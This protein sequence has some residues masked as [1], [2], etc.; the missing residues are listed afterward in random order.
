MAIVDP[1]SW[2]DVDEVRITGGSI[3]KTD[4]GLRESAD[5]S[6]REFERNRERWIRV[7]IHAKQAGTAGREALFT[8]LAIAPGKEIDGARVQTPLECYSVLKPADD[9]LMQRGWYAPSGANGAELVKRLLAVTPAPV[10]IEGE[11]PALQQA[12]IAEDGETRLS[13]ADKVLD[14]IGWRLRITGMGEIVICEKATEPVYT[15]GAGA[16]IVEPSIKIEQDWFDCPNVFRAVSDDMMAVARDD[17]EDSALSTEARGREIW[18]EET[19]CDMHDGETVAD[20]AMRRLREEQQTREKISY[21]RRFEPEVTVTDLVR[22]HYPRAQLEGVYYVSS[23]SIELGG[24]A[25][26]SEEVR[27]WT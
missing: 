22:L 17:A 21:K 14:A 24:G 25:G 5:I 16:D 26:V 7:W 18:K 8:G 15:F 1:E 19:S 10:I 9:V 23:Q 2:R 27:A 11:S 20:Y 3:S 12:I 4:E 13:M 6:C